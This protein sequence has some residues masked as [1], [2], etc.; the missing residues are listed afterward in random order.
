MQKSNFLDP[1]IRMKRDDNNEFVVT[2]K[3]SFYTPDRNISSSPIIGRS[4]TNKAHSKTNKFEDCPSVSPITVEKPLPKSEKKEKHAFLRSFLEKHKD[5][6]SNVTCSTQD[7]KG[8][9]SVPTSVS[10]MSIGTVKHKT[11]FDYNADSNFLANK[12]DYH[13]QYNIKPAG[14]IEQNFPCKSKGLSTKYKRSFTS[15]IYE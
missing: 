4:N 1:E 5:V 8:W 2:N 7:D 15:S 11:F 6:D 9:T 3:T 12:T 10:S 13:R 14:Y